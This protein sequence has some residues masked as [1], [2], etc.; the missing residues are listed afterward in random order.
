LAG[1]MDSGFKV[2]VKHLSWKI[3]PEAAGDV[4][5]GKPETLNGEPNNPVDKHLY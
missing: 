3:S 2:L 5:A 4:A 1:L